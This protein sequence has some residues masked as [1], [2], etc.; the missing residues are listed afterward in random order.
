MLF[1]FKTR[2]KKLVCTLLTPKHELLSLDT[3]VENKLKQNL[4]N[5]NDDII[6]W[7]YFLQAEKKGSTATEYGLVFG[8]FE[9]IVFLISP[10][11]GQYLNQIG[12]RTLFNGG[13]FTTGAAAIVFGLLDKVEVRSNKNLNILRRDWF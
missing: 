6:S 7:L 5:L 1:F 12:A 13:I 4:T 8:I 9:L 10:I 11:Y 2:E 3:T